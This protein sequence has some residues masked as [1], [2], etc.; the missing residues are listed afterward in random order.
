MVVAFIMLNKVSTHT[1]IKTNPAPMIVVVQSPSSSSQQQ[2]PS[3]QVPLQSPQNQ[4]NLKTRGETNYNQ[5]GVLYSTNKNNKSSIIPLYGR[6]T[7]SGSNKWNY[8]A[9]TDGYHSQSI[10]LQFKNKDCLD[11]TGCT[12]LDDGDAL[13]IMELGDE[14]FAVRKY[15][16]ALPQYIPY[17]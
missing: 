12:E 5:V 17:V 8:Y 3:Q 10:P 9:K 7:Y 13:T 1:P 2:E 4:I 6:P 15:Q 14:S 16:T 11:T